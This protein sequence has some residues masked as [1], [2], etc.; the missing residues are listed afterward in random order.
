MESIITLVYA[1]SAA[2][3]L[4]REQLL[5]LMAKA[6]QNNAEHNITGMLLYKDGN[7]L[8]VLEG[9]K[10]EVERTFHRIRRDRRHQD[11]LVLLEEER[12]HRTFPDW[13]M[14]FYD[15]ELT[16]GRRQLEKVPGFSTF[17]HEPLSPEYFGS[18]PS[19]AQRLIASFHQNM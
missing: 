9:P 4:D 14:A 18:H 1:S 10:D 11:V 16:E 6:R 12:T 19:S 8:Q 2:T 17:L 3:L 15:L 7:F 13:S 5:E